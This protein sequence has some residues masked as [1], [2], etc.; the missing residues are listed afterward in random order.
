MGRGMASRLIFYTLFPFVRQGCNAGLPHKSPRTCPQK[1]TVRHIP[2]TA[3]DLIRVSWGEGPIFNMG[4]F[5]WV[6]KN[7]L[8]VCLAKQALAAFFKA[9]RRAA[10]NH[11]GIINRM[12][13]CA[14]TRRPESYPDESR[15]AFRALA[16][17]KW[18]RCPGSS[19]PTRTGRTRPPAHSLAGDS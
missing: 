13:T 4:E 6:P 19:D 1:A 12:S 15:D 9:R 7:G 8:G 3:S 17:C 2:S 18:G 11:R 16:W 14:E 10:F 5:R